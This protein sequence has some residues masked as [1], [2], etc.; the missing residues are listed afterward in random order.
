MDEQG[1]RQQYA[2]QA[3]NGMLASPKWSA[4]LTGRFADRME[5]DEGSAAREFIDTLV[6]IAWNNADAMVVEGRERG[7]VDTQIGHSQVP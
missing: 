5:S 1:L 4:M 7:H 2:G 3:L 6:K